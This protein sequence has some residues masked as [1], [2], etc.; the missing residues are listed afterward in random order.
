MNQVIKEILKLSRRFEDAD[1]LPN[2]LGDNYHE[3]LIDEIPVVLF[4]AGSTGERLCKG[5]KVHNA[6]VTCFC[7]N[8][9]ETV[10]GYFSGLPVISIE[11]LMESHPE[12]LIVITASEPYAGQVRDRLAQSGF[13]SDRI[14]TL[15]QDH[16]IYYR[17][18]AKLHW[19]YVDL[20]TYAQQLQDT[21]DLFRDAKSKDL[22]THRMALLSGGFDYDSFQMFIQLFAD[23]TF[24]ADSNFFSNPRYDDDHFYFNSDF[25][26][27]KDNEVFVNVGAL[28]G[29]CALEFAK[30]CRARGLQ[31][32]EIINFEPDPNNFL[33][34]STNMNQL[35]NVKCL[36]YGLWSHKSLLRF[37]NPNQ[38]GAGTPGWLD[39]EG[40][41]E[42]EVIS[43]DELLPDAEISLIKMDVEG[44]EMEALRG[45]AN[46]IRQNRPKL[47]ISVYHKRDDI[48]EIPLYI[49]ELH[50]GYKFYLRHHSTTFS[51]TVLFATP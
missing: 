14:H 50:P 31:Y 23:M 32:K 24:R 29:N 2:V 12:G 3:V 21:Y 42:V 22:F 5:L 20:N 25:F 15:S 26:P 43:L 34:L 17:N 16:L 44:A 9:P 35:P 18:V 45:A 36:Q 4:G 6:H 10:G 47:A 41:L 28:L 46:T 37:A 38:S 19:S 1:F 8:D 7:D 48:F 40:A 49:R 13:S 11:D 33:Q 39:D 30:S 51:E 27:L